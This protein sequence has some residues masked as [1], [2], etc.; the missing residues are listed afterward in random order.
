[1][2]IAA[3]TNCSSPNWT[4]SP[5]DSMSAVMRAMSTPD[6]LRSKNASDWRWM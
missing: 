5:I 6:L 3:E 1:M 4:S 2:S